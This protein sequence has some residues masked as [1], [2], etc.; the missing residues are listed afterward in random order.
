MCLNHQI[1]SEKFGREGVVG[2][3]AS[4]LRGCQEDIL[5]ALLLKKPSGGLGIRQVQLGMSAGE[6]IVKPLRLQR[7]E[8]RR[9]REAPMPGN[10]DSV[11]GVHFD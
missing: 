10:I 9:T 11:F 8:D 2:V 4:D 7:P 6:Q 5:R 3:N 1:F